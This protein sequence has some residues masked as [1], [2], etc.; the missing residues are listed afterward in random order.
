M[1]AALPEGYTARP[2][3]LEDVEA[4]V[5]TLNAYS[6]SQVGV[7]QDSVEDLQVFWQTPGFDLST[8]NQVIFDSHGQVAGYCDFMDWGEPHARLTSWGAV[9]PDHRGH[10]LGKY[11]LEWS[12][13][14]ARKNIEKAPPDARVVLQ[15]YIPNTNQAAAD[16]FTRCGF[17]NVRANYVMRIEFDQPPQPPDLPE[18]V[19]IRATDGSDEDFRAALL[20]AHTAFKDHYGNTNQ[21]FEEQYQRSKH[22]R[23]HDPHFDPGVWFIAS[24]GE[25]IAGV[26][27]CSLHMDEDPDMGWIHTLGVLREWRKH[28]IGQAL[29]RHSFS[30]LYQ[31]GKKSAGLGVDASSL[32]GAVRLYERAGMR[33]L[34]KSDTYELELRPGRDLMRKSID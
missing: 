10:G 25:Q 13:A 33:V 23:D 6:R 26:S 8:D 31:R 9:H 2:A 30:A 20:V 11:L 22:R 19:S 34:R 18:G 29:L 1:N 16:L 12:V 15:S 32:T 17:Q 28:G 14:R 21:P 7:N 3:R 4:V 5:D 24:V 27:L